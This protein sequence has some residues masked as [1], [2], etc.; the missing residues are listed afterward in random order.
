MA[1]EGLARFKYDSCLFKRC[2]DNNKTYL[3]LYVDDILYF[4]SNLCKTRPDLCFPISMLSRYQTCA[5]NEL[6]SALK[7]ILRYVKYTLDYKLIYKCNSQCV[8][9]YCDAD[10]GADLKDRKSTSGYLFLLSNCLILWCSKKQASVSLSSTEAEYVSMS[11]AVSDACWLANLLNDFEFESIYPI[12][13]YCDNQSAIINAKT[14]NIKRLKHVDIRYHFVKDLVK[15]NKICID[16]I[17]TSQQQADMLTKA[18]CKE[19]IIRHLNMCGVQNKYK[20]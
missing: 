10:W 2:N 16:Y 1:R 3:L 20:N 7:R 18:L 14:D 11:M 12:K 4:G 6:L 19:L 5:N 13:I 15:E 9:G 8:T 17:N